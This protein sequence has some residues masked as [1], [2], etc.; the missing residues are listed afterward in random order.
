MIKREAL[1]KKLIDHKD[2]D[3]IKIITGIRRCGKSYLLF[4]IY[5]KYLIEKGCKNIAYLGSKPFVDSEVLLREKAYLDVMKEYG[6]EAKILS[7]V[8]NHGEEQAKVEEFIEKFPD[9]DGIFV[10]G[11]SMSTSLYNTLINKGKKIPE[12]IQIISYDGFFSEF[13]IGKNITCVEQP[14]EKMAKKCVDILLDLINK[15]KPKIENIIKSKFIVS[16]T[17]K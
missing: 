7:A 4:N 6:M 5:Y 17:T 2:K 3:I 11:A 16:K 13:T 1:L 10:S 9:I 8:I 14:V 12:E 15:K